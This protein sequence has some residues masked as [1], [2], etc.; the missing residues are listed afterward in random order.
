MPMKNR[1]FISILSV[2]LLASPHA[3]AQ[4][5][6]GDGRVTYLLPIN[7]PR[8]IAGAFGTRWQT[9]LWVYHDNPSGLTILPCG[10]LGPCELPSHAPGVTEKAFPHETNSLR[11]PLVYDPPKDF[12]TTLVLSSRLFELSRHTQPAGVY[13]PVIREDRFFN[14]PVRFIAVDG[15]S[16]NRVA[17][18]I[19]D[20]R[21]RPGTSV[22]VEVLDPS[23]K[24]VANATIPLEYVPIP[25]EPGYAFVDLRS[26]FPEI[27]ALP[28]Y[29]VR[30]TPTT[31]GTEYWA[32]VSVT[33]VQT[34]QVI[35]ITADQ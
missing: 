29:D 27:E 2:A 12:A 9:E 15:S 3:A 31:Q 23:N 6:N 8:P 28:R 32:L 16:A 10:N 11:G 17:L 18:R 19:Y 24:V 4:D 20:P 5:T 35:L 21:R 26:R 7:A 33:D 34:Q 14:G 25:I 1:I 22:H 13:M 30:L